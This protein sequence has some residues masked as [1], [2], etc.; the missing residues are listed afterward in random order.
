[1]TFST[2]QNIWQ[3]L[4]IKINYVIFFIKHVLDVWNGVSWIMIHQI[5]FNESYLIGLKLEWSQATQNFVYKMLIVC[6]NLFFLKT[7]NSCK[8]ECQP[9]L[10]R[11]LNDCNLK[12]LF[13]KS[14]LLFV[15][16]LFILS[17]NS[18]MFINFSF[19]SY[20]FSPR[21]KIQQAPRSTWHKSAEAY[22][23]YEHSQNLG[24]PWHCWGLHLRNSHSSCVCY[25][26]VLL[27]SMHQAYWITCFP[28]HCVKVRNF[29]CVKSWNSQLIFMIKLLYACLHNEYTHL[30]LL[31]K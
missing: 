19:N 18:V 1:M 4:G 28:R 2:V 14:W 17:S 15:C 30:L 20:Y 13:Y 25:W 29:V 3:C 16:S 31:F 24:V 11:L 5:Y 22:F 10:A 21:N 23:C 7:M 12:Y 6:S 8:S 26:F 27:L 9:Y